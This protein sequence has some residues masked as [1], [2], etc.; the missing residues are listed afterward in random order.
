MNERK[1]KRYHALQRLLSMVFALSMALGLL[2]TE[3]ALGSAVASYAA[4]ANN[5][6][7]YYS[8]N[9]SRLS[10]MGLLNASASYPVSGTQD[11]GGELYYVL[12]ING[13]DYYAKASNLRIT[14]SPASVAPATSV[15]AASP[16]N[17]TATT[18]ASTATST[19]VGDMSGSAPIGT[20]QITQAGTNM[21]AEAHMIAGNVVAV[22][23]KNATLSFYGSIVPPSGNHVWYY[24][25]DA[26]SGKFGYV[27][28]DCVKVLTVNQGAAVA[29][30][31]PAT[32]SNVSSASVPALANSTAVGYIRI[33][34][35]GK[36]N[37]RKTTQSS[38]N[39]VVAQAEQNEVLPYYAVSVVD[40][41]TW[42]Y[43]FYAPEQVFGYVQGSCA[44]QTTSSGAV[45]TAVPDAVTTTSGNGQVLGYIQ[46]TAGGVNLRRSATTGAKVLGQFDKD[47]VV[48][49]YGT[50]TSNG[51]TWYQVQ[52]ELTSGYVLGDYVQVLSGS[53]AVATATPAPG[54]SAAAQGYLM[55]TKDKVYIRKKASSDAGVYG[56]VATAGTVLPI[57]G[58]SVRSGSVTWYPVSY[59]G[60]IGYIHGKYVSVMNS[61]QSYAYANGL[62]MPTATP[63]PTAVPKPI[64]YIQTNTDKVWIRTSPSTK[65]STK[66]QAALGAV[67]HFTGTTKSGGVQW[68]KIEYAGDTCYIMAKYCRVMTDAEYAAYQ[69]AVQQAAVTAT[70]DPIDMSDMALTNT[71]KVIVRASGEPKGKQLI[72]LYKANQVCTLLGATNVA[73]GYTWYNVRVNSVTGW[74]RGDLLRILTKAEAAVYTQTGTTASNNGGN[75]VGSSVNGVILYKPELI[76][77]YTG[78]IQSIFY[79]GCVAVMTDVKTGIS[80]QVRRWSGGAHADVEPF[81]AADTAAFCRIYGVSKAQEISDRNLYQRRSVLVTV[82]GHTYAASIYGVPHNYPDGDTIPDNN[83]NGQFCI[84]FVNSKTHGSSS[85]PAH[86]DSDHQKAI[87]YA[88]ENAAALLGIR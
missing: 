50:V 9:G 61:D 70:P 77:W 24:C 62:P 82:A 79:K 74:I 85:N 42:Y 78:G 51:R 15:T 71:T 2:W 81:T 47:Q 22:L 63:A 12:Q 68:Y 37:I 5:S 17:Q 80:L 67:F 3:T 21:R 13:V 83:F 11:I 59:N 60:N 39:N 34:P 4:P 75:G 43:V 8:Y 66:G 87:M 72:L 19:T 30:L 18:A 84:H 86:V 53:G 41:A 65:A 49:Y 1:Q 36:T 38:T 23:K 20:L 33:T 27:V 48:P 31:P 55:T 29:T 58:A 16:V 44:E 10:S 14:A 35:K 56:Q 7:N 88:Y 57:V 6:V 52:K 76:D 40:K 73:G 32:A 54:S 69:G 64:D 46:F 25:Y 45:T 26:S 28:D